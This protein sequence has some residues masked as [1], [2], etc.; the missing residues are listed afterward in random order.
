MSNYN[1]SPA[2]ITLDTGAKRILSVQSLLVAG[3][4]DNMRFAPVS[5]VILEGDVL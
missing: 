1:T 4:T 3:D 2:K 5:S